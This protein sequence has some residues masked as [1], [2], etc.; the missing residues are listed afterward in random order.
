MRLPGSSALFPLLVLAMLAAFTFWLERATRGE[1]NGPDPNLRHDPD[2]WV[3]EL[4]LRRYNLDGSIQH[5]LNATRMTHYPDDD[6]TEVDQPR[7]AYFRDGMTTTLTARLA[8]LDKEGKHVRLQD[9]VRVIR[10]EPQGAATVIETSLLN[11]TPDD[12]Y[13]QTD[14]PVT[15]SQGR[16]VMHGTGGLEVNNKTRLVVLNGPVTGTIHREP[17]K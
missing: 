15:I 7:V 12:E 13:A 6:T 5:T 1:G 17:A 10:T 16:S 11:V 9:D 14:A 4:I 2:F 3:D 8:W